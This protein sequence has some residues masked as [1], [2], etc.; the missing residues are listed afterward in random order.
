MSPAV[1][2]P[3]LALPA[4]LLALALAACGDDAP[5]SKAGGAPVA[6]ADRSWS[7]DE[8]AKDPEGYLGWADARIV[9][10]GKQREAFL[11]RLTQRRAEVRERQQKSGADLSELENFLAR[12]TTAVRRAED[13]DRWPV[14][15]GDRQYEQGRARELLT[16]LPKQIALR[17]PLAEEYV[18][19]LASMDA[20]ESSVRD[21]IAQLGD[22]RQRVALDLERV[23]LNQGAGE[24]ANLSR[25]AGQI[26]HY[27]KILGQIT[28]EA[29]APD[30]SAP[31]HAPPGPKEGALI[32]LDNLL[33]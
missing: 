25:M 17:R 1:R 31:D 22:L 5:A 16:T 27:A 21:E 20:K 13:E 8:M 15:V 30:A 9:E 6:P 26:E 29:S 2:R 28:A 3:P 12:L 24:L 14:K 33:K 4:A 19:A 11:A 10:Q 23:R 18:K 7:N 32:S